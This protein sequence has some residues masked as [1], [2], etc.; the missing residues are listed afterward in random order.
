MR[1]PPAA[2][3]GG[4]GEAPCVAEQRPGRHP[5]AERL[6]DRRRVLVHGRPQPRRVRRPGKAHLPHL[7]RQPQRQLPQ[8]GQITDIAT[9][10]NKCIRTSNPDPTAD[11]KPGR[12]SKT[13]LAKTG[14]L[15]QDPGRPRPGRQSKT[16]N[17]T[18]PPV[19]DPADQD[20]ITGPRA[21]RPRPGRWSKTPAGQDPAAGPRPGRPRPGRQDPAA[22]P[23]VRPRPRPSP[24]SGRPAPGCPRPRPT[25]TPGGLGSCRVAGRGR[26]LREP[27]GGLMRKIAARWR[28]TL[29]I[30]RVF[31]QLAVLFRAN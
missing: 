10:D 27:Q 7:A 18:R 22:V 17:P 15:V 31:F 28:F 16:G 29:R 23:R 8:I 25:E 24:D 3:D 4:L 26:P 30:R 13:R 5:R 21:G 11:P 14:P 19:R 6:T 2:S 1:W 12:R 20:P 9:H